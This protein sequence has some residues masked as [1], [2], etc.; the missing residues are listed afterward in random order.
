MAHQHLVNYKPPGRGKGSK[1]TQRQSSFVDHYM[2]CGVAKD[3]VLKAG[4][5]TKN[6]IRMG[7]ECLNHPLIKAEIE[8]RREILNE[9]S[10]LSVEYL[11][12][13]L[14]SIIEKEH[15]ENPNAALRGIELAGKHL[16]MYKERQEISGPDGNAIEVREQKIAE[17]VA[18]FKSRL[19]GI[20]TRRGAGNLSLVPDAGSDSE[21]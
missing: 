14:I 8:R 7:T 1:L 10:I 16:G 21:S 3:A 17:D 13:K 5:K 6:P 9:K 11:V 19:A 15:E 18:D 20:A 4:Y 12:Q 2:V